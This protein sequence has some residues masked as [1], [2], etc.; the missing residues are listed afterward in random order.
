MV[1]PGPEAGPQLRVCAIKTFTCGFKDS[2][3]HMDQMPDEFTPNRVIKRG[4]GPGWFLYPIIVVGLLAAALGL[5]YFLAPQ[6]LARLHGRL[7]NEPLE[8]R[9]LALTVGR[10][11]VE[12]PAGSSVEIHPGQDFAISHLETNRWLNYDLTLSSPDFNIAAVVGGAGASPRS[13]LGEK[14]FEEHPRELRLQ[15]RDGERVAAVF[16]ITSHYSVRDFAAKGDAA[17]DP[18]VAAENYQRA[19]K[20]DPDSVVLRDKL[21]GAMVESGQSQRAADFLEA[22][23]QRLGPDQAMLDRLLELYVDLEQPRP[24]IKTLAR[25]IELAGSQGRPY[26]DLM[27]RM[28]DTYNQNGWPDQAATVF[29][30]MLKKAPREQSAGILGD[31]LVIYRDNHHRDQEINTLKRILEV[32]P[33]EQGAA[34]WSEIV[35]LYEESEDEEGRLNAWQSLADILPAGQDKI[36]ACKIIA[37][38][39]TKGENYDGAIEAYKA[40]LKMAPKDENTLLNLARLSAVKGDR[41]NYHSYLA[42]L[43]EVT[44]DQLDLRRELAD[45]YREDGLNPKARAEY[46]E[47]LKRNPEDQT[48][49]LILIDLLGKMDDKKGLTEQYAELS[50]RNPD[51]AV[52]AYNYGA[53]LYETGQLK[54]AIEVFKKLS[55]RDPKDAAV[56]EYLLAAYQ[57]TNQTKEM[58]DEALALYR[59]DP[60]KTVYR[61]LMLNTYENAKDWAKF[62]AVALEATRLTPD[63]PEAWRK[64]HQAQT[65]L[66]KKQEAAQSLWKIAETSKDKAA[67]W[68]QAAAACAGLGQNDRAIEAY[69]K[70]LSLD[71]KN[72]R[73]AEALLDLKLKST[74]KPKS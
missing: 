65:A 51:D 8:V 15:V 23:L 50:A 70:V 41:T 10:Q 39:H 69:Q 6:S 74:A 20:L 13:L 1:D 49:R 21:V 18:A 48:V 16:K 59:L 71:P 43:L 57:K 72:K 61:T 67:P 52:I 29:E 22:E 40:A 5:W 54:P 7:I 47:L 11:T 53:L 60:A 24:Q 34:I 2:V 73:A 68:L 25:L 19:L 31:L 3:L 36:N 45:A 56:R 66:N 55:N 58:L 64:L 35:T 30:E 62:E 12:V 63:D 37:R 44:P 33:P 4:A 17:G 27:R 46:L 42:K 32:S 28:A 14:A 38:L 26:L 9:S